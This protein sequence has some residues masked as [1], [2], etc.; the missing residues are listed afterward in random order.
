MS[1][2][3]VAPP[4][5][6]VDAL[7]RDLRS[8]IEGEVRVD[9][10]SRALYSTVASVYQIEPAGVVVP[11]NREDIV[12]ALE[13]CRRHGCPITMRGGGTSQGGQSVGHGLQIDTSKYYNRVLEI[14]EQ[15]RW[16]RVEPG[17]VLDELNARLASIGMRFAPDISTASRATIGGMMANNSSGARSVLY[18]KTID[19]VLEQ[20]V[21]LADGS[22]AH[23]REIPRSEIPSGG[24]LEAACYAAVLRLAETHAAEIDRRY[25]KILRRVGGYNLDEFSNPARPVNLAKIMVGSEGTLGIVLE[26]K[27][28]L[29]PLPKA[30][31]VMVIPFAELL[32]SLAATPVILRHKPSAVEVMDKSILDFTRQNAGLD[33]IRQT[34]IAGD[35][36]ATLCV[37]FYADRPEDLP[38]RLAA[39][40]EDLRSRGLG[41]A[42][43]SEL[44]LASQA[45]I[46]S[47]REAALGLSTAM[48]GDA[49]SVS[50]VEDTAVAP[51]K[52]RDFIER[53]LQIIHRHET[54]AGVYA[55][56]SVGCLHVRPVIDLKTDRGI[57]QFEAIAQEVA[58]L[59]LEFGG[60]LSGEHGDGFVRSP[61]MRQMFGPALYEAFRE[62]KR[63]FD[64]QGIFNPGK[65]VDSPPL[66]AN[67]RF[68]AGYRTPNPESWF[69]YSEFGGLAGAVEM[70]S[71]VGACR[72]KLAGTM[73]PSYMA[74]REESHST[75]G[76]A[77]VLRLAMTGALGEAGLG[78]DGVYQAL[79]LCLE[80]RACKS[81][82][83][84]G[85]DMARFKSEF[86]ADYL[87][88]HGTPLQARAL[89][90]VHRAAVWGSRFAPF[91]NWLAA[92]SPV[93]W[94]N[95][96]LLDIDPRRSLPV[97]K[98]DTFERRLAGRA[99][100]A[101]TR[102]VA[103]FND[104][105]TNHYDPEI[106]IA[107]LE[108]L[109]IGGC[110]V[111]VVRP[112]C[113]GRPLISKGL[114]AA[115]RA[116][117]AKV[118]DGLFPIASRGGRIL[119]LEPS[120]LSAVKEDAPSL[121]RG[122]AQQKAR[123]VAQ[124]CQL[125][126]EFAATLDLPL[127]AGPAKI[128]LHGHC[129]QKSM[130]LLPATVALLSRIPQ[131]KVVDLDAG[132][133][134]MAGSFGYT[135]NHYEVSEAI[136]NRKLLPA[137]KT[138]STADALVAPGTSC[139]HQ[140]AELGKVKAVH[141]AVLIRSLISE[142]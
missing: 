22:V 135:R 132:C 125:F 105:F 21:A 36:G 117:A 70:C 113:C 119:F 83:P 15:E 79:D 141:P 130:G 110:Q 106:G 40:E 46:W 60:A 88:R 62:I 13:I 30:K 136:A 5:V 48:K 27:L 6:A 19:H 56:A 7:E 74:T 71:G 2:V 77:N 127:R 103:L 76:R 14:N 42:Y 118:V 116:Q 25:P 38:P 109:E 93:R 37:E 49:K 23:F 84:V 26:A 12:R 92:S 131:S 112:D 69:D 55:H 16:V 139:R 98:R 10:I 50:F 9:K 95:G 107:A 124:A 33:R 17:I 66:T 24:T 67:L 133:C 35:P 111:D 52:L 102:E 140:V 47:L 39:L 91:S 96:K 53:F 89:G 63:T 81:E 134:G 3:Q 82:C 115:A 41:Y 54:T 90:N 72:K 51:E 120:C 29:V 20:V 64:P 8:R 59:V 57:R 97:W 101:G 73:C 94:L 85:V 86:L 43:H 100:A 34:Y 31:A 126:D 44:D 104:T 114:L 128:L 80:C 61:F 78:D 87:G 99:R 108:V 122:D 28:R 58:G 68:G 138:M 18:G 142:T 1:L 45:R 121:L 123:A 129:H 65:I 11:K 32:E 75:R 4:P 137:V